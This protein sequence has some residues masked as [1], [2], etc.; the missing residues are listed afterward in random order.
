MAF[1]AREVRDSGRSPV[2]EII[3]HSPVDGREIG[4]VQ[5]MSLDQVE[6]MAL[7]LR[8]AQPAWEA[9]GPEARAPHLSRWRDWLTDNERRLTELVTAESGKAWADAAAIPSGW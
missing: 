1:T 6:R 7:E 9:L 5:A 2:D 8:A 3:V 4:R